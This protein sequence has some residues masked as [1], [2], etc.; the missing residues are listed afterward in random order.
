MIL[1]GHYKF[2][3]QWPFAGTHFQFQGAKGNS[4]V[5]QIDGWMDG[6]MDGWRRRDGT[7]EDGMGS[8]RIR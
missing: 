1:M 7:G 2:P 4:Q 6:W 5:T 3:I 8:D